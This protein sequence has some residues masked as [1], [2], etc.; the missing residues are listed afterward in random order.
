MKKGLYAVLS[1]MV[2][3]LLSAFFLPERAGEQAEKRFFGALPGLFYME[4]KTEPENENTEITVDVYLNEEEKIRAIPLENYVAGV[5][6]AE[7]PM[8]YQMEAL[9]AQA[10]AARSY[11]LFKSKWYSG[12]GCLSHPG[13]DVCS[14]PGCCQGYR[15][16]D[17]E[18]YKNAIKAAKETENL[19]VTFRNHPIRAL[20]HACSG[21]HTENAENVYTEALA[22]LRGTPSP[23]EEGYSRYENRVEM[24]ISD[25]AEAFSKDNNVEFLMDYPLS[26]QMEILSKTDTGRVKD[27]RIGLYKMSG[28]EFRRALT[29]DSLNFQMEFDD[30]NAMVVFKTKGY[31]HGVGMSQAGAEAMAQNGKAFG[32][33]LMHYYTG[34]SVQNLNDIS[35]EEAQKNTA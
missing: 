19:I 2:I 31:G 35:W 4:E 6:A 10:V 11:A 16:P 9:N 15:P 17:S 7:M 27:V 5:V 13:A 30:E 1:L 8:N 25:L 28:N 33:I 22:Y 3:V 20:Y 34:V 23:G 26:R 14:S 24:H 29:L 21:G 18:T 12:E 32:E